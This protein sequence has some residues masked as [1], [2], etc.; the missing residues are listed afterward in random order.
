MATRSQTGEMT[1]E[2][3]LGGVANAGSVTR[4]GAYVLRPSNLYSASIHRFLSTLHK[5]GFE[6]ASLPAG[7]DGDGRER[8]VFVEGAVP[9]PPYPSWAQTDGTLASIASLMRRFHDAARS[10]DPTGSSWSVEVAE[11]SGG[12]VGGH[13][14]ACLAKGG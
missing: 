2:R 8:L 1:E 14:E 6:G 4:A 7:I 9:V 5:A 11:P 13:N 3:L 10:F 12:G